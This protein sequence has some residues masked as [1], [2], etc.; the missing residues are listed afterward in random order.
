[1]HGRDVHGGQVQ[2]GVGQQQH[3][4]QQVRSFVCF[5][6]GWLVGFMVGRDPVTDADFFSLLVGYVVH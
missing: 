3:G 2:Q 4:Y 1:M 5:L 6:L